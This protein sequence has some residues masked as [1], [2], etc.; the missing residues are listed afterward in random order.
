MHARVALILGIL[1][2]AVLSLAPLPAQAAPGEIQG[3]L[4][5][6]GGAA[7]IVWG[8]GDA[9]TLVAAAEARGCGLRSVW[10]F[11]AGDPSGYLVGAPTFVNA[12]FLALFPGSEMPASTILIVL[13][14]PGWAP[15]AALQ[16]PAVAELSAGLP[17]YSRSEW[18]HWIDADGDC[19]DTR[20]EVLIAESR[21]E[22]I[23]ESA[24]QC[25]VAS[26]EWLD[27]YTDE[28]VTDP[29]A[30]DVDHMVPLQN[31]HLSGGWD[32]LSDQR[33]S[34]ANDLSDPDHLIAVTASANRSKGARGPEEWKP[35]ATT[36][37]CRYA[38]DWIEVKSTWALTVTSAEW[39]ALVGMLDACPDGAP[40]ISPATAG[41][42]TPAGTP[43][44][45][46]DPSYPGVCVPPPPPDLNCG[47]ILDRNFAVVGSDPH[48]F[49]ANND[50]V[51]CES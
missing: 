8:G 23:F 44:V 24:D 35:P 12:S 14:G 10:V 32:W 16:Q 5:M 37:W 6:E 36:Y 46:C 17:D 41:T 45:G 28:V 9:D 22:V 38:V 50:G 29:G 34:Y 2:A 1:L 47:D 18:Q 49:D 48:G 33:R 42:P 40:A 11:V 3:D 21:I 43:V 30:L 15:P 39:T 26:G 51:G 31:A 25:R 20:Q 19:Q 4:P 27:P 7:A 13:C